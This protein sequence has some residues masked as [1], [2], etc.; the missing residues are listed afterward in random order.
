AVLQ[1]Q[2][3]ALTK[4]RDHERAI[5]AALQSILAPIRTLPVELLAEIFSL[6]IREVPDKLPPWPRKPSH[7]KDAFRV[8][9][10]CSDWRWIATSTP[11]LW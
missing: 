1:T 9:H 3:A 2:V 5:A 7:V 4:K 10:V 6:T 8:A 11:R